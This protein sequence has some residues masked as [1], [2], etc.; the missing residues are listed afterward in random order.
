MASPVLLPRGRRAG[1]RVA[2]AGGLAGGVRPRAARGARGRRGGDPPG[3]CG[4]APA[5]GD[6]GSSS[7]PVLRPDIVASLTEDLAW[8]GRGSAPCAIS[9]SSRSRSGSSSDHSTTTRAPA[10]GALEHVARRAARRGAGRDAAP[11]RPAPRR[12][13]CR[14]GLASSPGLAAGSRPTARLGNVASDLLS[15]LLSAVRRA[16]HDLEPDTPPVAFHRLRVRVKRLR[17]ALRDARVT[18]AGCRPSAGRT[19]GASAGRAGRAAGRRD[20]RRLAACGRQLCAVAAGH[21]SRHGALVDRL[22]RRAAKRRVRIVDRLWRRCDR[23]GLRGPL[24]DALRR[25]RTGPV[26]RTD[27]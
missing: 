22:E 17:Y 14:R 20:A 12:R 10:L 9:T 24:L 13:A 1:R 11:A 16:G 25:L 27:R 21:A 8:L 3:A 4:D 18:G 19:A 23:R 2:R 26:R 6:A 5:A 7:Q 15:P